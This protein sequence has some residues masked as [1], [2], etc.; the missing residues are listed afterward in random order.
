MKNSSSLLEQVWFRIL[1]WFIFT[2]R[3]L[4]E[5]SVVMS[6]GGTLVHALLFIGAFFGIK[7]EYA[8]LKSKDNPMS[9]LNKVGSV[10][11]VVVFACYIAAYAFVGINDLMKV[12]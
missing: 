7:Q 11:L 4:T 12:V 10:L 5:Y 8:K 9:T 6:I 2:C 3:V 1:L